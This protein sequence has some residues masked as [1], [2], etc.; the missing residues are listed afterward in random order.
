MK[1]CTTRGWQEENKIK[2]AEEVF[3]FFFFLM[4]G[5]G[6]GVSDTLFTL[7][8][9]DAYSTICF[10]Q[11]LQHCPALNMK[12]TSERAALTRVNALKPLFIYLFIYI[13]FFAR[14]R[15]ILFVLFF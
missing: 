14:P 15:N 13:F 8:A 2:A 11:L 4:L 7:M 9:A 12:R 6:G 10:R 3:F 5:V 1:I